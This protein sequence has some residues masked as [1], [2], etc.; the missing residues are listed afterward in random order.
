V[1][2]DNNTNPELLEELLTNVCCNLDNQLQQHPRL[3]VERTKTGRLTCLDSSGSTAGIVVGASQ[4]VAVANV[5]DSRAVIATKRDTN[6]FNDSSQALLSIALSTDHKPSLPEEQK[7]I[8]LS[9]S[10]VEKVNDSCYQI[11]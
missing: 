2:N 10:S 7:R 4:Y 11:S 8:E 6:Q 3:A 1:A 9:G 5:G